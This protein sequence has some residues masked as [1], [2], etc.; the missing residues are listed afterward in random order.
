MRGIY[1]IDD[2]AL[3]GELVQR[4]GRDLQDNDCPPEVRNSAAQ[5]VVTG[6]T[7]TTD[8]PYRETATAIAHAESLGIVSVEIEAPSTY[9]AV[10]GRDV[11]CVAHVNQH[12]DHRR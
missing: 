9:A 2:P 5:P 12:H 4:L 8:A 6:A 7:W 1:D 11:I 3:A 10:T